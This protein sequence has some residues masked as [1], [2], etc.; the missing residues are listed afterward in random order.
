MYVHISHKVCVILQGI[1]YRLKF[2]RSTDAFP[3][4]PTSPPVNNITS[5]KMQRGI[6]L[7]YYFNCVKPLGVLQDHFVVVI[8]KNLDNQTRAI[9]LTSGRTN[10]TS[11]SITIYMVYN[12]SYIYIRLR[13]VAIYLNT[14]T[15][16]VSRQYRCCKIST[17]LSLLLFS[18]SLI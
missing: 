4:H 12:I 16:T 8:I 5:M 9:P 1:D 3:T 13:C 18:Y 10:T 15:T 11:I 14:Y 7:Y 6:I 17:K 2:F